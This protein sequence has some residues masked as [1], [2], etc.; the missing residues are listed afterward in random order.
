[1]PAD[2][3]YWDTWIGDENAA[4]F[5]ALTGTWQP[6]P[7]PWP[8]PVLLGSDHQMLDGTTLAQ[9]PGYRKIITVSLPRT[10]KAIKDALETLFYRWISGGDQKKVTVRIATG[11]STYRTWLCSW[12][13]APTF[14]LVNDRTPERW[15]WES[16]FLVESEL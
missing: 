3:V 10:T 2:I 13:E 5:I 14:D 1:M 11:A 16:K 6:K 9:R 12:A 4:N 15:S 7:A 8:K